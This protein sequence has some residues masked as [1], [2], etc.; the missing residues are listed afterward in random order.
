MS[1]VTAI[2]KSSLKILTMSRGE[3]DI[4]SGPPSHKFDKF[5]SALGGLDSIVVVGGSCGEDFGASTRN[6]NISRQRGDPSDVD[7]RLRK[8]FEN[9]SRTESCSK[10]NVDDN[11]EYDITDILVT[12]AEEDIYDISEFCS[13]INN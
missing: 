6:N 5:I 8:I 9:I 10:T 12:G 3:F 13:E 1:R 7:P 11:T 2:K 4:V